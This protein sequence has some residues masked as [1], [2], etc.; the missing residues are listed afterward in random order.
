MQFSSVVNIFIAKVQLNSVF[1]NDFKRFFSVNVYNC[2]LSHFNIVYFICPH[3]KDDYNWSFFFFFFFG[4]GGGGG[5][6]GGQNFKI[7]DQILIA[8]VNVERIGGC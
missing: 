5:G 7:H 4:G 3:L 6:L 8:S 2:K 1:T